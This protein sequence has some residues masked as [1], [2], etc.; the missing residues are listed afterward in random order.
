M[1][2]PSLIRVIWA[3]DADCSRMETFEPEEE[4]LLHPKGGGGTDM[5]LPLRYVE[6]FE[7]MVVI[8][9]TDGYTPWPDSTPYPLLVLCNTDVV[10][11]IGDTIR[12][13]T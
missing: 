10:A 7:P 3:D 11:P 5:R 6:Q 8:L 1:I 13:T 2:K 4:L 12:V 9:I